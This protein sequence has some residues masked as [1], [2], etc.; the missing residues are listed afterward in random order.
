MKITCYQRVV[1]LM[2]RNT[3]TAPSAAESDA[4]LVLLAS[5]TVDTQHRVVFQKVGTS[6]LT[7]F[8]EHFPWTPPQ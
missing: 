7:I 8:R 4:W 5:V 3:R 6:M 2:A 1:G